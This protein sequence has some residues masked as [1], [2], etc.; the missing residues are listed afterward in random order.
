MDDI[1]NRALYSVHPNGYTTLD[2]MARDQGISVSELSQVR[3]LTRIIFPYLE[4]E[5]GMAIP[6]I[7]EE[8]G[9]SNFREMVP[10]LKGLIEGVDDNT[11]AS[12][13]DAVERL[14]NDAEA[15]LMA[16]RTIEGI[17]PEPPEDD[18]VIRA[19]ITNLIEAGASMTNRNLRQT[20]RPER[21]ESLEPTV[22]RYNNR[23][24]IVMTADEDQY[25]LFQRK[26]GSYIDTV[27]MDLPQDPDQRMREA[28]RIRALRE[29][30]HLFYGD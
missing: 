27:E 24:L 2:E 11:K 4:E 14:M 28:A 1:E 23:R 6:E 17:E 20:I 13:A 21:T 9:K 8:I 12:V 18:E 26:M 22:V 25:T 30:A 7:W 19:A 16:T 5:M 29:V 15:S 3:D 10:V